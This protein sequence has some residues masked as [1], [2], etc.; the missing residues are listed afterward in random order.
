M[1]IE[2]GDIV[3]LKVLDRIYKSRVSKIDG[4]IVKLL[5]EDGTYRQMPLSN[6]QEL[7]ERGLAKV[8]KTLSI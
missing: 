8:E 4:N 1:K 2:S 6:L 5:E 7:V 3:V